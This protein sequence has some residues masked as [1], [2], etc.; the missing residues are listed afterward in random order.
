MINVSAEFFDTLRVHPHLGR[1]FSHAEEMRGSN[2]VVILIDS[3][4]RRRFSADPNV[5]GRNIKLAD[6]SAVVVGVA[7]PDLHLCRDRELGRWIEMPQ[8]TDLF[9]PLQFTAAKDNG[10]FDPDFAVIARLKDGVTPAKARAELAASQSG[11]QYS[12]R[13]PIDLQVFV[14]PVLVGG[15]RKLFLLLLGAA[16]MVLLIASVNVANL[17]LVRATHRSRE[18]AIRAALGARRL[19]MTM[20]VVA[21]SVLLSAAASVLGIFLNQ[22]ITALLLSLAPTRVPRLD[23]VSIDTSFF[24]F[25][26]ALFAIT[27]ILFGAVPI[28]KLAGVLPQN[29]LGSAS[30]GN[31]SGPRDGRMRSILVGFEM[32]LGTALLI[33]SGLLLTSF[34]HLINAPRG[35]ESKDVMAVKI[36]LPESRYSTL[37]RQSLFCKEVLP[38][39]SQIPGVD[40]PAV[41]SI[42]PLSFE[43]NTALYIREGAGEHAQGPV[44]WPR[45]SPTYFDLMHISLL[46]GRKFSEIGENENVAILSESAARALWPNQNPIGKRIAHEARP[47][48]FFRIIG[49]VD[50]VRAS[51]L[52]TLATPAVYRLFEQRGGT[53]LSSMF[54]SRR[55]A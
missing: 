32:A 38:R 22:W 4:W 37:E 33:V 36:A 5:I 31:T 50:D 45:V 30:R 14:Q 2:A 35:F 53:E 3:L 25:A 8:Q 34:H 12:D 46:T 6:G 47:N 41:A 10:A 20:D 51:G 39:L 49:T 44:N 21:E 43:R 9:R 55:P 17:G 27:A 23:E 29:I 18:F 16:S 54:H 52:S 13:G 1:W 42:P 40:Q 24:A 15:L 11:F 7:P 26:I 19:D 28:W 48:L